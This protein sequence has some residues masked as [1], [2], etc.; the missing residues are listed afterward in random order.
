MSCLP[1]IIIQNSCLIQFPRFNGETLEECEAKLPAQ[2]RRG[3][4]IIIKG[5]TYLPPESKIIHSKVPWYA[6]GNVGDIL[7]RSQEGKP[8]LQRKKHGSPIV[9]FLTFTSIFHFHDYWP[10]IKILH[11]T[12]CPRNKGFFPSSATFWGEKSE[13]TFCREMDGFQEISNR[14]H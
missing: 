13:P 1:I 9:V 11:R 12:R 2:V 3:E 7:V 5:A 8:F 10:Q 14:T 6:R 4:K